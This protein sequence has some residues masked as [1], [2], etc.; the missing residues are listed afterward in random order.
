MKMLEVVTLHPLSEV[1]GPG[2]SYREVTIMAF[3]CSVMFKDLKPTPPILKEVN[4]SEPKQ[5]VPV[6]CSSKSQKETPK[7]DLSKTIKVALVIWEDIILCAAGLEMGGKVPQHA[8]GNVIADGKFF[9]LDVKRAY[10][11]L[12]DL[13]NSDSTDC[14]RGL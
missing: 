6:N 8:D 4:V 3:K 10:R 11:M 2:A 13:F 5:L 9:P 7:S 12:L 1:I 14:G